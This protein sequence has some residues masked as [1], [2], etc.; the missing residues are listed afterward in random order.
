[1]VDDVGKGVCQLLDPSAS[2]CNYVM[3]LALREVLKLGMPFADKADFNNHHSVHAFT[4][5]YPLSLLPN[6]FHFF[7]AEP[8]HTP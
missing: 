7:Q 1:M 2:S 6:T 4:E 5:L 3:S 8:I